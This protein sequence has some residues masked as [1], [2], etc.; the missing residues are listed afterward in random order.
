M[1]LETF[2]YLL[3]QGWSIPQFPKLDS[4]N[5]WILI[6]ASPN[7]IHDPSPFLEL[8]SFY[9]Q[10]KIM[11]CSSAGEIYGANVLDNSISV[12]VIQFEKTRLKMF[13]IE[14]KRS[15]DSYH[16]G[17]NIAQ[18]CLAPDLKGIF[19]LSPGLDINGSQLVKGMNSV[20]PENVVITGG[21]AGDGTDFKR[22]W[23]LHDKNITNDEIVAVGFYGQEI[24]IGHGSQ[25]GMDIFGPERRVT[26]AEQNILYELDGKPALKLYKEY[27]GEYAE[28][29]PAA[30]LLFP[31]AIRDEYESGKTLVRTILAIDEKRQSLTFAGE[32]PEGCFARLMRAN[33]DR[34]VNSAEYAAE[35]AT[36]K[37]IEPMEGQY[38]L[39]S[40]AISCVGRRLLLGERTEEETELLLQTLPIGSTQIGFYS[41]GEISPSGSGPCNL[42]NQTMT[43]TT[44]FER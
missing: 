34:V 28:R 40:I 22:T 12:A 1:K 30:G 6:F 26:R 33:F 41:Y 42:H 21:L 29:L 32:I 44:F 31:L 36:Q 23:T 37:M 9:T 3:G 20:V 11:G 10:A 13:S 4:D 19:V 25:G 38:S 43:L 16:T 8:K 27:L 39:L 18:A 15:E 14:N 7:F 24:S 5:T 2:Q 35:L 17:K